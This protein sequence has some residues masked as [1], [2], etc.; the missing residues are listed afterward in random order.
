M[1]NFPKGGIH[2]DH[3]ILNFDF[4]RDNLT[5]EEQLNNGWNRLNLERLAVSSQPSAISLPVLR[6]R[7][8]CN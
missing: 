7:V 4:E 1:E 5:Q 8:G 3:S 6:I 2:N